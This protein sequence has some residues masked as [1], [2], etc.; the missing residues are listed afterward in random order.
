MT[1]STT[2]AIGLTKSF[3][4]YGLHVV[5]LDA[6][7]GHYLS[8]IDLPSSIN[9]PSHFVVL[10]SAKSPNPILA[11][12]DDGHVK[13]QVL[14]SEL[15]GRPKSLHTDIYREI[16]DIGVSDAGVFVALKRDGTSHVL[17]VSKL[18]DSVER[19]WEFDNSVG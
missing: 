17:R 5:S 11:W 3:K 6:S 14:N 12:L 19:V 13:S 7:K 2:F 8:S 16:Q 15:S 4:S 9:G 18:S 10:T 1:K